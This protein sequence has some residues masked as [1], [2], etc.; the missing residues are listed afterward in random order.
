MAPKKKNSYYQISYRDPKDGNVQAIKAKKIADSTLGLS[1]IA[2]SD[3]VFETES[4]VV[5]PQEEAK[6]LRFEKVKILHLSIYSIISIEEMDGSKSL[7]F[8][9]DKSDLKIL[10]ADFAGP[11]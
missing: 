1:F 11:E 2:I 8:K 10:Q 4:I 7:K 3:F 6:Q 5:N 9:K